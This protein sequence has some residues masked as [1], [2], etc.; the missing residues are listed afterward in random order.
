MKTRLVD[1][2]DTQWEADRPAYRV[3]FWDRTAMHAHEHEVTDADADEVLAWA[4]EQAEAEGWSY[5]A[6]VVVESDGAV[7]LVRIG[8]VVGD[9]WAGQ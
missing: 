3:C 8:G 6:C 4:K 9:P 7:G 1:P 5:T 2:R